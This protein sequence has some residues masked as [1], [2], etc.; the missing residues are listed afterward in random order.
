[1]KKRKLF[2]TLEAAFKFFNI[3]LVFFLDAFSG[4]REY[5][6]GC[7]DRVSFGFFGN[8]NIINS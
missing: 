5:S 3:F 4:T 1:M 7:N 2:F 6:I 8:V